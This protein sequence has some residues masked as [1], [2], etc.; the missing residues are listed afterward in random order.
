MTRNGFDVLSRPMGGLKVL[1]AKCSDGVVHAFGLNGDKVEATP[2][3][4]AEVGSKRVPATDADPACE[5]C[6]A[7]AEAWAQ[8]APLRMIQT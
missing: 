4:N 1:F 2:A 8:G 7:A 3:C 6:G 5:S